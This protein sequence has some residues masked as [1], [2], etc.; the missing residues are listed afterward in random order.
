MFTAVPR[1]RTEL[2]V[3]DLNNGVCVN[4]SKVAN[5]PPLSP[6]TPPP[7]QC[8]KNKAPPAAIEPSAG[9]KNSVSR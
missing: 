3:L 1:R 7:S 6:P 9:F 8:Q 5:E 4:H 2:I